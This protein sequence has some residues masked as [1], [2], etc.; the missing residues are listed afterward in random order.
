MNKIPPTQFYRNYLMREGR[1]CANKTA[2]VEF[3]KQNLERGLTP[4][5]QVTELQRFATFELWL[6]RPDLCERPYLRER[7]AEIQQLDITT[8]HPLLLNLLD[9]DTIRDT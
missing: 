9:S 5:E 6:Q 8:A 4:V 3:K 2:Y 1:Y 7:L